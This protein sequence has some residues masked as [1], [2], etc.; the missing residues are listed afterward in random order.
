MVSYLE[1][2]RPAVRLEFGDGIDVGVS[3]TEFADRCDGN[4]GNEF[5]DFREAVD[6]VRAQGAPLAFELIK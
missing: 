4:F 5:T 3:S 2:A 6:P 1:T